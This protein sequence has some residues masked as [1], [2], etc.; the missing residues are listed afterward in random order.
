MLRSI[1][2]GISL[3]NCKEKLLFKLSSFFLLC[4]SHLQ[5]VMVLVFYHFSYVAN[6]NSEKKR[7]KK[8]YS[9]GIASFTD[10]QTTF[11]HAQ[12]AIFRS[13]DFNLYVEYLKN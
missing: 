7:R 13:R 12:G 1:T 5:V 6:D 10:Q 3:K 9:R 11:T 8:Q 2:P 4:E